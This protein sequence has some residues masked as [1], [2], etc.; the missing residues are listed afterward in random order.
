MGNYLLQ[1][2]DIFHTPSALQDFFFTLIGMFFFDIYSMHRNFF[3]SIFLS[4]SPPPPKKKITFRS[5]LPKVC[6]FLPLS[7]PN[8]PYGL[9]VNSPKLSQQFPS[10][11]VTYVTVL[12]VLTI[13][14]SGFFL[15]KAV[16]PFSNVGFTALV[17]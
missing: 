14:S 10:E 13:G 3:K 1:L 5:C 4:Q 6:Q 2:Y 11:Q 9:L 16:R 8:M 7:A 12:G 15:H 17:R